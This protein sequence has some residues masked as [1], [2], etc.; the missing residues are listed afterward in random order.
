MT[1]R[2]ISPLRRRMIDDM[3][4]RKFTAALPLKMLSSGIDYGASTVCRGRRPHFRLPGTAQ[5]GPAARRGNVLN[6]Q[7]RSTWPFG[8]DG[9]LAYGETAGFIAGLGTAAAWPLAA[10]AQQPAMPVVGYVF[11]GS[12]EPEPPSGPVAAALRKGLSEAGYVMGRNVT[13]EPHYLEGQFGRAPAVMAD[14]VRRRVAVIVT[15]PAATI[16]IAAKAATATIPIVFIAGADPVKLGLVANLARPGGNATGFVFL[17]GEV[18]GKRLELLHKLVPKAVRV[19]ILINPANVPIAETTLR[20][21]QEAAPILGLQ[22]QIFNA[23][24]IG[25][26]DAVFATFARE[27]P[28]AL[29]V[30][31][32]AFFDS[33]HVQ[34]LTLTA[35]DRIPA[36]YSNRDVVTAGGLMSYNGDVTEGFYVLGVYIGRILKGEKPADLPVQQATRFRFFLNLKT[37]RALGIEV[38]PQLLAIT[39]EVIDDP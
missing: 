35:R 16:A 37:A 31:P 17:S 15:S 39:D 1:E 20:G 12:A 13:F 28:D 26:I 22:I 9:G 14:L 11:G 10:R 2:V 24:T 33:R 21:V 3:A 25:E 23:S 19:A 7:A 29:F 4:I 30:A 36:T 8:R 27:R 38:P 18:V 5:L 6:F 32:D 34:I